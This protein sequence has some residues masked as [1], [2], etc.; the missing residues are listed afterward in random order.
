LLRASDA[1][2]VPPGQL[3]DSAWAEAH[4][5]FL[6]GGRPQLDAEASVEARSARG[7][8]ARSAVL[9]QIADAHRSLA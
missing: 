1:A 7:G 8:T 9:T 3:P 2:G 4:A 6:E 5:A